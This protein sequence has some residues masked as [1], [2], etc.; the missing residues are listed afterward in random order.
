MNLKKL[1]LVVSF[2][3]INSNAYAYIDP[4]TGGILL[5]ALL[6]IVAAIGA[7]ITLFWRKF[8]NLINKIFKIRK[9][10]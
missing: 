7:Y 10:D 4:G 6:G 5:Q 8:K 2:V 9:K 1:F 3:L